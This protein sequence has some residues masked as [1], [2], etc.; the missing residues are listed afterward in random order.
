MAECPQQGGCDALHP[1]IGGD[2]TNLPLAAF[3]S[4]NKTAG[5]TWGPKESQ[6]GLS[7]FHLCLLEKLFRI[8]S[9]G[10]GK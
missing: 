10:Q 7:E 6:G 1:E 9:R 4:Q 5:P 3:Q 8:C 2:T